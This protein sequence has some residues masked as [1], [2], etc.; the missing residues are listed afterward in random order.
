MNTSTLNSMAAATLLLSS[1][2]CIDRGATAEI[3][4]T[5]NKEVLQ[6]ER[7]IDRLERETRNYKLEE[8]QALRSFTQNELVRVS[9]VNDTQ[10][11]RTKI[12]NLS[13]QLDRTAVEF[14][15]YKKNCAV[16]QFDLE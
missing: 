9:R 10:E 14:Q 5:L 12:D 1:T 15:D 7:T 13:L 2:S 4:A 8:A 6:I 11:L 16:G 3:V